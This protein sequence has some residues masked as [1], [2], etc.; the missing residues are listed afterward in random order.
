M[1][2]RGLGINVLEAAQQRIA[3]TFDVFPRIYVSFSGGKDSTVMLHL[4]MDEAV[5]RGRK[6]GVLFVDLEGQYKL[7][8]E[9]IQTMLA[10]YAEH[11]EVYWICLPL[12][13]DNA[14]SMFEPM[15]MTWQPGRESDWIRQPPPHA[16]TDM[17]HFPFYWYD[18]KHPMEFEE[19]VPRFG[20]WY[21]QGKLTACFV[22]IRAAESL[23]RWRS[24]AGHG[25]KFEGRNYV[26]HVMKSLWNVYPIYDWNTEDIW[27]YH[28]KTRK[29]YNPLYDLMQQAGLKL[30]QMRI[31]Q[32]YGMDQRRGLWLYHLIEPETWAR[33]VARVA[34]V[35]QG[36]Q[37]VSL[38]GNMLGNG[39]ITKPDG[40]TWESFANLLLETMP[41]PTS[42]HYKNKFAVY[43]HW[44][45]DRDYPDGIPDEQEGD[46]SSTDKFPSW[47][48]LCK[49][50]LRGDYYCKALNF[51]A[52]RGTSHSKYIEL[53]MKR[54]NLWNIYPTN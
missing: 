49:V 19:F 48:R 45:Y 4:V 43:L 42:E 46:L 52:Q 40:H 17:K 22:G 3:W 34:G 6:V 29:P 1:P 8:I 12:A 47:R 36:A 41:K 25:T 9:H 21:S 10:L 14:V 7:T 20:N 27:V 32:P 28:G 35:N 11:I 44:W 24:I 16:I 54:R 2:K 37:Y 50:L 30:S 5:K 53:M 38:K 51:N 26:Q 15:W 33:V 13:L 31:C 23:N 18:E 39:K